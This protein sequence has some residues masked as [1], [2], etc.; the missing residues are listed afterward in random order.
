MFFFFFENGHIVAVDVHC[1][2]LLDSSTCKY[3]VVVLRCVRVRVYVCKCVYDFVAY[4][5]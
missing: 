5:V 3:V 4:I 2:I 1:D